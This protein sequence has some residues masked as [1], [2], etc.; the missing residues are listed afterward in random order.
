MY[1]IV[2]TNF[3]PF[4]LSCQKQFSGATDRI[5]LNNLVVLCQLHEE[6]CKWFGSIA[7]YQV[8]IKKECFIDVY[9]NYNPFPQ[10]LI[11]VLF[12][13]LAPFG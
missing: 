3:H 7:D 4:F 11:I 6:G 1:I 8:G 13:F 12:L 10:E 9:Y 5:I 2:L